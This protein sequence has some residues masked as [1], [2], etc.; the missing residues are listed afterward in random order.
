[1]KIKPKDFVIKLVIYLVLSYIMALVSIGITVLIPKNNDAVSPMRDAYNI[2]FSTNACFISTTGWSV[3]KDSHPLEKKG[4]RGDLIH[5]AM[6][7]GLL[8]SGVFVVVSSVT[9]FFSG[10]IYGIGAL[11]TLIPCVYLAWI[12]IKEAMEK[13]EI[14]AQHDKNELLKKA[15]ELMKT[16]DEKTFSMS[17]TD[18]KV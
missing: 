15:A 5:L 7:S 4:S 12:Y 3:K 6:V 1:M 9:E 13:E 2:I 14:V 10:K 17:G 8:I 18:F 11:I 16:K